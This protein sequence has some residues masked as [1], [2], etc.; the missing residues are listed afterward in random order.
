MKEALV[1]GDGGGGL[2]AKEGEM[3]QGEMEALV[4]W[5]PLWGRLPQGARRR[6]L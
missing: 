5:P 4:P 6:R 1:E 2:R 3:G